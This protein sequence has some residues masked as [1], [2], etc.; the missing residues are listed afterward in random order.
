MANEVDLTI[1]EKN[2]ALDKILRYL[3]QN[4]LENISSKVED[5]IEHYSASFVD[6]KSIGFSFVCS[7]YKDNGPEHGRF[8]IR[9]VDIAISWES[10]YTVIESGGGE[11]YNK[12]REL[13]GSLATYCR[14]HNL[15]ARSHLLG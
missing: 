11:I 2:E 9:M 6:Q 12:I 14:T 1:D 3:K 8:G 13:V 10:Y 5:G 15:E 7:A 4:A